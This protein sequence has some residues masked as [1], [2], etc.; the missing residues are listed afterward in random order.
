LDG[1]N[2]LMNEDERLE[3]EAEDIIKWSDQ[4]DFDKYMDD[5]F[6]KSTIFVN[7]GM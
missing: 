4:L 3:K 1:E 5:W 7:F 2:Y 6:F